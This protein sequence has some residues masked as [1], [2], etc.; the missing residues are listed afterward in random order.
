MMNLLDGG[1]RRRTPEPKALE[2]IGLGLL[3]VAGALILLPAVALNGLAG[4]RPFSR[5]D[6]Y[7]SETVASL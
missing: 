1:R 2:L 6:Q 4:T 7:Q 5:S 3:S